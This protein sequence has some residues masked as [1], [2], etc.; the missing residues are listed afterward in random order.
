MR[1][2]TKLN[3]AGSGAGEVNAGAAVN[4]V[5]DLL[6]L[7][8]PANR[9]LTASTGTGTLEGSRGGLHIYADLNNDGKPEQVKGEITAF[10][11][12]WT[13]KSWSSN[14]WSDYAWEAKSWSTDSWSAKSWSGMQWDGSS[15]S[16][17]SWSGASWSSSYWSAKSWSANSWSA[18]D[19]SAKSWSAKSWSALTWG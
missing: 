12:P 13:A 15:W 6:G 18:N 9:G 7:L 19:W 2:A 11:S 16:A 5:N 17:N 4:A 1:T 14:S 10:G 3:Q 8:T